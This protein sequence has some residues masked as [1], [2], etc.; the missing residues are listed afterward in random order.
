[1]RVHILQD[2]P[3][4]AWKGAFAMAEQSLTDKLHC[5]ACRQAP[6]RDVD[7][8]KCVG[9]M[10]WNPK[11]PLDVRV[12]APRPTG[13]ESALASL[14]RDMVTSQA[15]SR[16]VLLFDMQPLEMHKTLHQLTYIRHNIL[17]SKS[18]SRV[19]RSAVVLGL[20]TSLA[21]FL[22]DGVAPTV[23]RTAGSKHVVLSKAH[24]QSKD[25]FA[26]C[27]HVCGPHDMSCMLAC[28]CMS[29]H[30]CLAD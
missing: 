15:G 2:L 18:Y 30:A 20:H 9:N 19:Y 11:L 27:V 21:A 16:S 13:G 4:T 6:R 3:K 23:Y 7:V 5:L 12:G 17:C 24:K 28:L 29:T 10:W 25:L 26:M 22:N 14:A 8:I 1:M